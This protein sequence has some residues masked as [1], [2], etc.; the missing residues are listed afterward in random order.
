MQ[1]T[2]EIKAFLINNIN[3]DTIISGCVHHLDVKSTA[4]LQPESSVKHISH[5]TLLVQ[6][7][8]YSIST[9]CMQLYCMFTSKQ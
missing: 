5:L 2:R 9:V 8:T 4:I 3:D 7:H 1:L 6:G